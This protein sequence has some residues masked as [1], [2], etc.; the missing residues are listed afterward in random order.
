[1]DGNLLKKIFGSKSARDVKRLRPL[2]ARI[3]ALE[4]SY[5]SLTD[6]QLRA[7][8]EEFKARYAGGESLDS[9]MCEAFAAVKNA[10]RRMCGNTYEV[11][12]HM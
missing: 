4:E 7:K 1:M 9:I 5:Q 3:N 8:T 11:C 12:G 6:E 2:V 10:C